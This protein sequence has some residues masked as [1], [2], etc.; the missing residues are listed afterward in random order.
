MSRRRFS[1]AI[2]LAILGSAPAL[3]AWATPV[4]PDG[5][6]V[7]PSSV[8]NGLFHFQPDFF[9]QGRQQ[10]EREI[11]HLQHPLVPETPV[12][13]IDK[14]VKF[15]PEQLETSAETDLLFHRVPFFPSP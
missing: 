4:S 10:F 14:S 6:L 11:H 9:D 7:V 1:V 5:G 2:A 8:V 15:D 3:S 12:L 13:T